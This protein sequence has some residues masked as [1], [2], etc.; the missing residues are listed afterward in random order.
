MAFDWYGTKKAEI[1]AGF[2]VENWHYCPIPE[3]IAVEE[4]DGWKSDMCAECIC[5]HTDELA[6]RK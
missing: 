3:S 5:N 1:L 4:C 2:I 6:A